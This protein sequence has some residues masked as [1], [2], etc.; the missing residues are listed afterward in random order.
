ARNQGIMM[1]FMLQGLFIGIV[2]TTIGVAGGYILGI[3]LN[4]YELIKLPP[5]IY[6]LSKLPVRMQLVDFL[7]VSISAITI[8]FLSTLYPSYY[9]ARLDPVESLRYE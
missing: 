6:Y 3:V 4:N 7:V 8:S 2:G 9:A 1:I 5:D